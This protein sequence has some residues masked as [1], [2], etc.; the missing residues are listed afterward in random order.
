MDN[1]PCMPTLVN[2]MA[3]TA[4]DMKTSLDMMSEA[5]EA[6]PPGQAARQEPIYSQLV[7]SLDYTARLNDSLV[8][9]IS[10]YR[11][12]KR[13]SLFRPQVQGVDVLVH[14]F[15]AQERI[16]MRYRGIT[17]DTA[18]DPDL[19]WEYD[20]AMLCGVLHHA[21]HNALHYAKGR[22]RL[23]I[24]QVD[25][26][27]EIRIEDDGPGFPQSMLD[28]GAAAMSG[29]Y[30]GVNFATRSTGLG[31]YFSREVVDLHCHF[32]KRASVRLENGGAYGGGCFI[33]IV[34]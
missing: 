26:V 30:R 18:F 33:I 11:Q 3:S 4:Q 10:L 32:G 22:I 28:A 16:P 7:H 19:V 25:E 24:V 29:M 15:L 20:V 21:A 2:Y 27:L 5:L 6:M 14:L 8:Q 1:N 34:P 31:L 9:W 13:A 23:A 12:G 17:L